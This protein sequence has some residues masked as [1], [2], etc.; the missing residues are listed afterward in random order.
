VPVLPSTAAEAGVPAFSTDDAVAGLPCDSSVLAAVAW[1]VST[2]ALTTVVTASAAAT[3]AARKRPVMAGS[4]WM[5]LR[6]R[7]LI[8]L[9]PGSTNVNGGLDG[10][11][12]QAYLKGESAL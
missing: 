8:A 9:V 10:G 7:S 3:A 2:T 11:L 6:E 5:S 12:R 4:S 1:S